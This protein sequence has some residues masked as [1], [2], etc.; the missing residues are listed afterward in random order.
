MTHCSLVYARLATG[1]CRTDIILMKSE[2]GSPPS[3]PAGKDSKKK[4]PRK[5]Q[6]V[7]AVLRR[8]YDSAV[9]ETIPQSMLDLLSKLD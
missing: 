2:P 1:P 5:T 6:D 3:V 9:D 7:N 8:A 4:A